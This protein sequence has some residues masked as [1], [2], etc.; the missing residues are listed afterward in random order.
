MDV[1][2]NTG[3]LIDEDTNSTQGNIDL[4][5]DLLSGNCAIE[6]PSGFTDEGYNAATR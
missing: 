3:P 2:I 4:A 6:Q 5:G 1:I